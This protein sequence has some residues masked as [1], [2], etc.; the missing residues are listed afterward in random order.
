MTM[1]NEVMTMLM[2][3]EIEDRD[4]RLIA[5]RR[6]YFGDL[7]P[8]DRIELV[9][10][11]QYIDMDIQHV[12]Q[13]RRIQKRVKHAS[14]TGVSKQKLNKVLKE[15]CEEHGYESDFRRKEWRH[16]SRNKR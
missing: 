7:L 11:E 2:F 10:I 6:Y 13:H 5:R 9:D 14:N 16:A 4:T 12:Q 15:I 3:I 8:E 1:L